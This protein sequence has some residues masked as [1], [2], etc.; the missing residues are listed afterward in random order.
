M[1]LPSSGGRIGSRKQSG[2]RTLDF[3]KTFSLTITPLNTP[4][5]VAREANGGAAHLDNATNVALAAGHIAH[6]DGHVAVFA[7][8]VHF[9][10]SFLADLTNVGVSNMEQIP[11]PLRWA[12]PIDQA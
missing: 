3:Q 4:A 1:A 5:D 7:S 8:K 11:Q 9:E 2:C 12:K 10:T 6:D